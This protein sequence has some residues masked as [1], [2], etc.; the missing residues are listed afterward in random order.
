MHADTHLRNSFALRR[1]V[2]SLLQL[3][4]FLFVLGILLALLLP[5]TTSSRISSRAAARRLATRQEALEEREGIGGAAHNADGR[6]GVTL[7]LPRKI[8]YEAEI[9]LTVQDF[10]PARPLSPNW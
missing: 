2:P 7:G 1:R 5:A 10:S 6:Q 9:T 8:I 3:V 4:L